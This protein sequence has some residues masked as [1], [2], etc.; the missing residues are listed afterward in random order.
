MIVIKQHADLPRLVM[1]PK[2]RMALFWILLALENKFALI[3]SRIEK[4]LCA[5]LNFLLIQKLY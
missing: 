3:L 1:Y 5:D 2:L 4:E